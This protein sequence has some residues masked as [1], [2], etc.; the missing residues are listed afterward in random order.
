MILIE[1]CYKK[2]IDAFDIV[3]RKKAQYILAVALFAAV[4]HNTV[5]FRVENDRVGFSRIKHGGTELTGNRRNYSGV[6]W[7]AGAKR[8]RER[9][10]GK[11]REP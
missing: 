3:F 5:I 7:G 6:F 2:I 8:Q 9:R 4:Y 1:M 11:C 10:G